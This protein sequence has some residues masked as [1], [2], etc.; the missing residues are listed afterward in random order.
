MQKLARNIS[1][2]LLSNIWLTLLLLVLTPI[3]IKI[4]GVESYGLIGFYL[5]W[6][7]VLSILDTGISSTASRELAW[8][9]GLPNKKKEAG[10][11]F[12]TLEIVYWGLVIFAGLI[13][14]LLSYFFGSNWFN[15]SNLSPDI[16]KQILLLM[17]LSLVAQIPSGLYIGGLMGLQ[18]QAVCSALIA[19]FGTLRGIGAVFTILLISSDL[20]AF[21][22]WQIILSVIQVFVMQQILWKDLGLT[23][24][25]VIFSK[26]ILKSVKFFAGGMILIS[27][28]GIVI[29]QSDKIILSH[30]IILEDLGFYMLA[31]AVASSLSRIAT[32]IVQALGPHFTILIAKNDKVE[33][34]NE[35]RFASQVMNVLIF[36]TGM[37]IAFTARSL[38]FAWTNDDSVADG[39]S[40]LLSALII[41]MAFAACSYP[42]LTILY[43]KKNLR[44]VIYITIFTLIFMLPT[45][46]LTISYYGAIGA[47][48]CW[49]I[50]GFLSL[51]FYQY[52]G[53]RD[54]DKKDIL[55]ISL[56]DFLMPFIFAMII[57]SIAGHYLNQLPGRIEFVLFFCLA[58]IIACLT[59]TLPCKMLQSVIK[60]A[61][62]K[63][64]KDPKYLS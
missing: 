30:L 62:K 52:Y 47:A 57:T 43:S 19:L 35:Y 33:L 49:S 59:S 24:Q 36:P 29:S 44:P 8:L 53:L 58:L 4:L 15:A 50:Y 40:R 22:V 21:F 10:N 12:Y 46:F 41:G 11:L 28:L 23:R 56:N 25:S 31:W 16:L 64:F 13:L 26:E 60:T 42:A 34:V 3:Y 1:V 45:L 9:S 14:F 18:K 7:A 37:L 17:I 39:S 54:F 5:S 32:P 51:L 6:V 55:A 20:R 38:L 61:L 63:F 48:F 2:N 27:I